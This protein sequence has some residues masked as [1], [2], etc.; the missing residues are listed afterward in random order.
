MAVSQ[1][2]RYG[3]LDQWREV[4]GENIWHFNQ[5]GGSSAPFNTDC[6]DVYLQDLRD[7]IAFAGAEAWGLLAHYLGYNPMPVWENVTLPLGRGSPFELQT[8]RLPRRYIQAM[9]QR[10]TTLIEAGAAIVYSDANS[11]GV[12]DTATIT[13]A[14]ALTDADEIQ[15]FFQVADG[16][17]SA[18]SEYYQIRPASVTITGGNAV[19]VVNR[20]LCVKPAKFW[21]VPYDPTDVNYLIQNVADPT[22]ATDFITAVDVYRVYN[23]T[24]TTAT[25]IADPYY[26]KD[27][28]S[29]W[30]TDVTYAGI[31]WIEDADLGYVRVRENSSCPEYI[32]KVKLYYKSGLP[33][34]NGLMDFR[35]RRALVRLTNTQMPRPMECP[36]CKA[37]RDKYQDDR[38]EPSRIPESVVD[39]PLGTLNGQTAAWRTILSMHLTQGGTV[40]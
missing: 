31:A 3:L 10:A 18:A 15:I 21:D 39:N 29:T 20:A 36:L 11:D 8:I 30:G 6:P 1:Y 38:Y 4:M 35:L 7:E 37:S 25:L 13:S 27:T 14:T 24:T 28:Q 19:I 17:D 2:D 16:A 9:G 32:G 23:D 33:L 26:T 34:V 12:D 5:A 40:R 22:D